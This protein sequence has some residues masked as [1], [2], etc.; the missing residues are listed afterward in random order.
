MC[1]EEDTALLV[2]IISGN[3]LAAGSNRQDLLWSS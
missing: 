3:L 2:A 1:T